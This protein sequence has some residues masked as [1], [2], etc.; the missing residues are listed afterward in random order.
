DQWSFSVSEDIKK[1]NCSR[2]NLYFCPYLGIYIPRREK[3]KSA[4]VP[5]PND[6]VSSTS[7]SNNLFPKRL[8]Q[9]FKKQKALLVENTPSDELSSSTASD[10]ENPPIVNTNQQ[11]NSNLNKS[12]NSRTL[13]RHIQSTNC[14]KTKQI[15]DQPYHASCN[16]DRL[17]LLL[18]QQLHK[19]FQKETVELNCRGTVMK[20]PSLEMKPRIKS[21]RTTSAADSSSI[22]ERYTK[23]RQVLTTPS[24]EETPMVTKPAEYRNTPTIFR[25]L[26]TLGLTVTPLVFS[27]TKNLQN[28]SMEATSQSVSRVN[29]L[30]SNEE[31]RSPFKRGLVSPN[32]SFSNRNSTDDHTQFFRNFQRPYRYARRAAVQRSKLSELLPTVTTEK[33]FLIPISNHR[34][35]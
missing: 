20:T 28:C 8:R 10:V 3:V 33:C 4:R 24:T 19:L 1:T 21:T 31:H 2:H 13:M 27:S 26:S 11:S 32:D 23:I 22:V 16:Q 25:G 35:S 15:D 14:S 18:K 12:I 29:S 9:L 30:H 6:F 17:K 5:I 34:N 7:T